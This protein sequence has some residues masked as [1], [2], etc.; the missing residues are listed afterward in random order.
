M[1][2]FITGRHR[3]IQLSTTV[4]AKSPSSDLDV[5]LG[6]PRPLLAI[7]LLPAQEI[8]LPGGVTA[9]L[10]GET[11]HRFRTA[12][13]LLVAVSTEDGTELL[14][15]KSLAEDLHL[16]RLSTP[17]PGAVTEI[18]AGDLDGDG[19]PEVALLVDGE[20]WRVTFLDRRLE[21]TDEGV[22]GE[23]HRGLRRRILRCRA[24]FI[25]RIGPCGEW[26]ARIG[27]DRLPGRPPGRPA[28]PL[29]G[30]LLSPLVS[31]QC[32]N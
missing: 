25:A 7:E 3:D 13:H 31:S 27:S 28:T 32:S 19:V 29:N 6:T 21:T 30:T 8:V 9:M 10:G 18:E 15:S 14:F 5:E 1:G 4:W 26:H 24:L 16:V 17:L 20:V 23:Y 11:R 2:Y 12:E 22:D